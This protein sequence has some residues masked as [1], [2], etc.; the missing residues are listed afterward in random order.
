MLAAYTTV[1]LPAMRQV[2]SGPTGHKVLP[3]PCVD[4]KIT[5]DQVREFC[6]SH[7]INTMREHMVQPGMVYISF[8]TEIGSLYTKKELQGAERRLQ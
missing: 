5:A 3:I 7:Q 4:G 6:H 2:P 8:P 1:T